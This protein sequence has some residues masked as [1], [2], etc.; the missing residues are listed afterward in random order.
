VLCCSV[1]LCSEKPRQNPSPALPVRRCAPTF[2][3]GRE[4][5]PDAGRESAHAP[6]S[7]SRTCPVNTP[8]T[9]IPERNADSADERLPATADLFPLVYE[10]LRAI[11]HRRL[12]REREGH[13]LNTTGLVHEAYVELVGRPGGEW[14]SRAHFLAVASRVMRHVLI[15]YARARRSAKRGG[16]GIR[17]QLHDDLV[18][19]EAPS[20]D[21]LALDQALRA[22]T[23]ED[24]RLGRVVEC[25][26]FGGMSVGE[27]AE[28]L[29]VGVRTVE[30]DWTRAK[31][32]LYRQLTEE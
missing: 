10:E 8:R 23:Q 22:L 20:I 21:L 6:T 13:T 17:V 29:G 32:Y 26:Y 11:A 7:P 19:G 9:D 5:P 4:P 16:G 12:R 27:T 18:G 1:T 3:L 14:R 2:G 15:D 30:R 28:V 31:A 25:R 24:E